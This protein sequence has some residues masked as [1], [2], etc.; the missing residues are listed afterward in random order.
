MPNFF[1]SNSFVFLKRC[2]FIVLILLISFFNSTLVYAKNSEKIGVLYSYKNVDSYEKNDIVSFSIEWKSFLES[3]EQAYLD[4]QFLCN[5]SPDTKVNDIGVNII[6]FP[7]AVDISQE[8]KDFLKRF[9]ESGGRIIVSSGVG[10]I[11]ENLKTFLAENGIQLSSNIITKNTL[12]LQHKIADVSF[13]LHPGNFHSVFDITGNDKKV[14][15]RWKQNNEIAIGGTKNVIYLGYNWGQSI[16]KSK[17]IKV[18]QRSLY[19]FSNDLPAKLT[20]E[21]SNSEYKKIIKDINAIKDEAESVLSISEQ[22]NLPVPKS[23]LKKHFEDGIDYLHDFHSNYLFGNYYNAREAASDAKEDFSIVYSLGIPVRKVEVRAIWLDRGSIVACK[24]AAELR[25]TIRTIAKTG[26]NV[27]FFETL[28]AGFP[29]YP[30][31]ILGQ[32]PL[33]KNWDPLKVAIEEAH[34]NNIE[35]HAWVWTFAVGNTRHNLLINKPLQYPGPI[36]EK[37]GRSVSLTD[38]T[39]KL[40]IENQPENWLSPAN[41]RGCDFLLDVYSE[42]VRNYDVDGIQYDYIRFPFQKP[43]TQ[44]GFDFATKNAFLKETGKLPALNGPVNKIWKEWKA[45]QVSNF[46]KNTSEK[47]KA[48]KPDLK[49]SVAVFGIDRSQRLNVI[50]QDWETW[51][52][53]KWIDAAYPFYYSYTKDEVITKLKRVIESV[54]D[55][56]IIIPSFNLRTLSLG[57]LTERVTAA[58]NGGSLGICFFANEHLNTEKREL[59]RKGPFREQTIF[60]PYNKPYVACQKLLDEFMDIIENY[61]MTKPHTILSDSQA[62]KEVYYLTQDLKNDFKNFKP[63]KSDDIEKK[64]I[65]LQL[66]VKDW[67]SLEKYLN[68]S[69]RVYYI[70]TYLDQVRTLLNYMKNSKS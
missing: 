60:I 12:S 64:L 4:Y 49:V 46:V 32:N 69:Q 30:S 25:K 7:L 6:Y 55:R 44:V 11:S 37:L 9:L 10:P 31:K 45:K 8:E 54:N 22:L 42:I 27:I 51:L 41:K 20:K 40:R 34:A 18:F 67:L 15:A 3:F 24:D 16:D 21:I 63:E 65:I 52:V 19:Y 13:E 35:L 26:F 29:I 66:K 62:Q 23:L 1:K 28:N 36:I 59:L 48:I 2:L 38:I 70:S 68:R 50:Q 5:F 61:A 47:L 43:S 56:A 57:E 14:I 33:I 17:D 58:R 53:N 39:T